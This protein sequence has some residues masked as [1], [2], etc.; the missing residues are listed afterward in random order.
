MNDRE[1]LQSDMDEALML[2]SKHF[3]EKYIERLGT[4]FNR[5]RKNSAQNPT[6]EMQLMNALRPFLPTDQ[7]E[8]IDSITEM[9]TLLSTFDNIRKEANM[10]ASPAVEAIENDR[11]VREDGIY[12]VDEHC[13]YKKGMSY[14]PPEENL[15][16]AHLML[17]VGLMRGMRGGVL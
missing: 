10:S 11:A 6:K 5:S 1:N 2:I 9:L 7:H 8:K 12:E 3:R 17:A 13:L 15:S 14:T 16:A 4:A